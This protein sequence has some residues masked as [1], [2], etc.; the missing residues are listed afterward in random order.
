MAE[1][2][3]SSLLGGSNKRF[4]FAREDFLRENFDVDE[5]ISAC[6]RRVT[7]ETLHD[8]LT[9]HYKAL[10]NAMMELINKDYADFVSLSSS[11]VS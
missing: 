9:V 11:L 8:D 7:L 4:C 6:R 10:K 3:A 1:E 2:A 5:F